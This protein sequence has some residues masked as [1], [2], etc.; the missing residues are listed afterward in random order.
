MIGKKYHLSKQ[1]KYAATFIAL[2]VCNKCFFKKIINL[3]IIYCNFDLKSPLK[4]RVNQSWLQK[5]KYGKALKIQLINWNRRNSS[6]FRKN[7]W[8]CGECDSSPSPVRAPPYSGPRGVAHALHAAPVPPQ[9]LFGRKWRHWA[10]GRDR[11]KRPTHFLFLP[12]PFAVR[13]WDATN[14]FSSLLFLV[15]PPLRLH[16]REPRR[17][18]SETKNLTK[19]KKKY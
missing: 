8:V 5:N 9:G 19:N 4:S 15:I 18:E 13:S 16:T 14:L 1:R 6:Y 17:G 3:A 7:L 12:F 2:E 10:E 11:P